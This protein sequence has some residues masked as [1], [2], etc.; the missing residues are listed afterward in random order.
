MRNETLLNNL[1]NLGSWFCGTAL[2]LWPNGAKHEPRTTGKTGNDGHGPRRIEKG[3]YRG[4]IYFPDNSQAGFK[5]NGVLASVQDNP[6]G[7]TNSSSAVVVIAGKSQEIYAAS[8]PVTLGDTRAT[9][10]FTTRTF[11]EIN[12]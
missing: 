1:L 6:T 11:E 8:G 9:A 12:R 3:R 5:L 10:E 4:A 7:S 2:I